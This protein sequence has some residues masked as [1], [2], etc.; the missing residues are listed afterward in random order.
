MEGALRTLETVTDMNPGFAEA[1]L[2]AGRV[3]HQRGQTDDASDHYLLAAHFDPASYEAHLRLGQIARDQAR[4]AEAR[5]HLE[6]AVALKP[7]EPEAHNALGA[8]LYGLGLVDGAIAHFRRALELK[9][10]FAD[11]HS[12]L[13]YVLFHDLEKFEQGADHIRT[14]LDLDPDNQAALE[15]WTVVLQ[16]QGRFQECLE[17]SDRLLAGNPDL[18]EVRFNRGLIRLTRGDFRRGW[19]DYEAR[20]SLP[21]FPKRERGLPEWDGSSLTGKSILIYGEQGLGDEI[22]FA[23]C[24]PDV[25]R[26]A[27]ECWI[28]CHPK[29]TKLMRRSF[30]Q[31]HVIDST[32]IRPDESADLPSRGIDCQAASG[33]LPLHLRKDLADFPQ[34]GGYLKPDAARVEYWARRLDRLGGAAIKVGVSWR[35]GAPSTRRSTRSIPLKLWLPILGCDEAAFV[36]LQ[37]TD[38]REEIAELHA[39]TGIVVHHWQDALDDYDETAA[40]V[41]AL[42]LVITVQTAVA[43]LSGAL[44]KTA[45]VMVPAVAEWRYMERGERMPWYPALR[46]IRQQTAGDWATVIDTAA[47]DL[48]ELISRV[49][50]GASISTLT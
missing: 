2:L 46:L 32:G 41:S 36:S 5:Q 49:R 21:G 40:L 19:Q 15:N 28:E 26:V 10:D 3:Y 42:D 44:G 45:W 20:K 27:R 1:H 6:R 11:A 16:Q 38:C 37:Y 24:L 43:H 17:L 18:H 12:N 33:S 9:P 23:S 4:Y 47:R 48:R 30:P 13:G 22:M 31:A 29:L 50:I 8:A 25:V 7:E 14:A 35:G 39:Q 34:H